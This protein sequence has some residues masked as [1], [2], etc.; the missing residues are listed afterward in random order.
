MLLFFFMRCSFLFQI[1]M[2]ATLRLPSATWTRIAGI[3]L[4]HTAAFATLVTL[5]TGKGAQVRWWFLA[6][7]FEIRYQLEYKSNWLPKK[8]GVFLSVFFFTRA[9]I[10][11]SLSFISILCQKKIVPHLDLVL[12]WHGAMTSEIWEYCWLKRIVVALVF[13]DQLNPGMTYWWDLIV[14][15]S[16]SPVGELRFGQPGG[17]SSSYPERGLFPLFESSSEWRKL[18]CLRR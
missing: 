9:A 7:D 17:K 12:K 6:A 18:H 4:V 5:T 15:L 14:R 1:L 11:P 3:L 10:S 13:E 16:V 8:K 2:N